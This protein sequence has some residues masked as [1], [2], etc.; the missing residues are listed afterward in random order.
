[1]KSDL[2]RILAVV[3]ALVSAPVAA[4]AQGD[5]VAM[6]LDI[7]GWGEEISGLALRGS[8]GTTFTAHAFRYGKA[9]SYSGPAVLEIY[10]SAADAPAAAAVTPEELAKLPTAI[11]QVFERRKNSPGLVALASLPSGSKRATVL[12]MPAPGGAYLTFVM[13]DDPSKLPVGRM[14][15]HNLSPHPLAIRIGDKDNHQIPLHGSCTV[16]PTNQEIFYELAYQQ[17]EEWKM[18]ENNLIAVADDEQTQM[19]VVKSDSEYFVSSNGSRTGYLQIVLLRRMPRESEVMEISKADRDAAA[20]E[21]KRLSDE[22]DEAA[23][24]EAQRKKPASGGKSR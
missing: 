5:Q 3:L 11:K 7:V 13:D 24:P 9:Q 1:M 14:R 2:T 23:K 8:S 20:R 4:F 16:A 10:Q 19:V 17:D 22:M 18:L 12:L 21:A 6:R 15:V